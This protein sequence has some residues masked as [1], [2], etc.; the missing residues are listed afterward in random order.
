MVKLTYI[1]SCVDL[2]GLG[3]LIKVFY[4][5]A[6]LNIQRIGYIVYTQCNQSQKGVDWQFTNAD[7]RIKLKKL[8]SLTM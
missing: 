8:Y 3:M 6:Y 1:N 4:E 2:A 7:A 5:I